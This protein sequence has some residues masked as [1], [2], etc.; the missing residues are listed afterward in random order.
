MSKN[1]HSL[2]IE[3]N[4]ILKASNDNIVITDGEGK[5]LK[6]SPNCEDIYGCSRSYLIGKTVF[7]LEKENIFTPSVSLRVLK[8]RKEVQ[9]MQKTLTGRVVMATGIPIFDDHKTLIRIISFSHD[10]TEIQKLREDYEHLQAKMKQYEFKI[11][12]LQEKQFGN[13]K[14]IINSKKMQKTWDL[15]HRVAKSDAA[16]LLLGESGVGKTAFAHALHDLSDRKNESFIEVNCGAIPENLF[17]SEMFGYEAGAFTGASKK[18]KKGMIE[19]ANN[20]TLFLDEI[21]DLSLDNQVKLLQVLQ[22]KKVARIGGNKMKQVNFRLAAATN[23]NLEQL[24]KEKKFRQDLY[25]RLNVVP[26]TI[27]SLRERKEDIYQLIHHCLSKFNKKYQSRKSFHPTAIDALLKYDW[28]GNVREL[29][30]LIERLV[31]TSET[32]IIYPGSLP[33][34]EQSDHSRHTNWSE[35]E[36]FDDRYLTLREA[37]QAVE[38]N[39]LERA[40]RQYKST[41]EMAKYLGLSQSTVVR[42]LKKYHIR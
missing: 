40:C 25:Y 17:E 37:L 24:V 18:G 26:I 35:L 29:E 3:L 9:V 11:K 1:R 14:M 13:E 16:V 42:R 5:V 39:W 31:I 15:I 38:K 27:P 20:G 34:N 2:E 10:L 23:Q 12:E 8:E 28:P 22:S 33:F 7:E 36:H 19:L 30:N 32:D 21:G 41:Y 4:A 6:A